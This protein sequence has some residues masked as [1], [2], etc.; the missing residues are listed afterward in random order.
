M[1]KQ[2]R[3]NTNEVLHFSFLCCC[4]L[5][6]GSCIGMILYGTHDMYDGVYNG[7]SCSGSNITN[8]TIT[9]NNNC[10][11]VKFYTCVYNNYYCKGVY[12]IK[13]PLNNTCIDNTTMNNI[14]NKLNVS[15][16]VC[17]IDGHHGTIIDNSVTNNTP[18]K[19]LIV[20]WCLFASVILLF[21]FYCCAENSRR[22]VR[23]EYYAIA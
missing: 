12:N 5:L 7:M 22:K 15:E 11:I 6:L 9:T 2:D 16:F 10:N 19:F 14:I 18:S 21:C 8:M 4:V 3:I 17:Y 1:H 13:Y 23:R 20:S